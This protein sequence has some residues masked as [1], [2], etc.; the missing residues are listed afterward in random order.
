MSYYHAPIALPIVVA[1]SLD[2]AT[3]VH[4]S[5]ALFPPSWIAL[6]VIVMNKGYICVQHWFNHIH[7]IF[8]L[9][10]PNEQSHKDT[11]SQTQDPET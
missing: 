11:N 10:T 8:K 6:I 9:E 4:Y 3:Q 2:H 7:I 5:T 1:T